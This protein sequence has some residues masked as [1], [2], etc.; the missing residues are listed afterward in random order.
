M[1]WKRILHEIPLANLVNFNDDQ[2]YNE[3]SDIKGIGEVTTK[4]IVYERDQFYEDL[5]AFTE[6]PNVV[7][8]YGSIQKTIR[9]TGFRDPELE[10]QL[11][12]LRYDANSKA[13]VTKSTSILLIPYAGFMSEKVKKAGERTIIVPVDEFKRNMQYYLSLQN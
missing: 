9:F 12:R 7:C 5:V 13:S 2:L 6:M 11:T 3:L 8:T 10:A 4:A 1:T